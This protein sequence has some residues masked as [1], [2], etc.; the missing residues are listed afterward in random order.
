MFFRRGAVIARAARLSATAFCLMVGVVT[1]V[2]LRA[3]PDDAN[4]K[5]PGV[6]VTRPDGDGGSVPLDMRPML[7]SDSAYFLAHPLMVPVEGVQP[8][9][10]TDTFHAA[11]S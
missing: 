11:R 7:A 2:N 9:Q 4:R 1:C 3:A 10:L 8:S 5:L 6:V